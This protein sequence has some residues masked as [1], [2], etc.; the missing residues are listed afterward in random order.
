MP[1]NGIPPNPVDTD[2][3]LDLYED[4]DQQDTLP[5]PDVDFDLDFDERVDQLRDGWPSI[6]SDQ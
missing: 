5:L 6:N 2:D 4:P 3:D 1:Q